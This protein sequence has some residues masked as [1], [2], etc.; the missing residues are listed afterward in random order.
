MGQDESKNMNIDIIAVKYNL[1]SFP[2][3][4]IKQRHPLLKRINVANNKFKN[5]PTSFNFAENLEDLNIS[6]NFLETLPKE[7]ASNNNLVSVD[8]S[9]NEFAD[10]PHVPLKKLNT[11]MIGSNYIKVFNHDINVLFPKLTCFSIPRNQFD[12]FIYDFLV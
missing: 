4:F 5:L 8:L 1:F 3:N 6:R 7:F 2:P 9:F 11:L 10:F 12:L